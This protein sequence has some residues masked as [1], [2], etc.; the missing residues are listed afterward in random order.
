MG[1]RGCAGADQC[2]HGQMASIGGGYCGWVGG[3]VSMSERVWAVCSGGPSS[4][5]R[6]RA[7]RRGTRSTRRRSRSGARRPRP[8]AAAAPP[9]DKPFVAWVILL[10]PC[11]NNNHNKCN[12]YTARGGTSTHAEGS[13]WSGTLAVASTVSVCVAQSSIRSCAPAG[14]DRGLRS[15]IAIFFPFFF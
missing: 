13:E 8:P 2:G 5:A 6:W 14:C 9:E 10:G 15:R 1:G 12:Y 11:C 4:S 3:L 7:A